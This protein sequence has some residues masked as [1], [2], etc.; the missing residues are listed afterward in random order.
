MET[1]I[2]NTAKFILENYSRPE[3]VCVVL[4][5][6]R[7]GLFLRKKIADSI[8]HPTWA[9]TILGIEEFVYSVSDLEPADNAELLLSLFHSVKKTKGH[10]DDRFEEFCKWAPSLLTDYSEID[11]W[12]ADPKALFTNLADIKNIEGWSL[13]EE[14]LTEFQEKF[15]HFWDQLGPWYFSLREDMLRKKKAW[16]G[17]AH[18]ILAENISGNENLNRWSHIVIVG[19]NA[20]SSSQDKIFTALT[21]NGKAKILW[22]ADRYYLEDPLN[23]AGL[24]LRRQR[25]K[26][27]GG[28]SELNFPH[29]GDNIA[30]KP[31]NITLIAAAR[32]VSQARAAATF[33]SDEGKDFVADETTV[34]LADESLLIPTLNALPQRY[35][36][37]NITMGYPMRSTPVYTLLQ[38]LFSLQENVA[39]FNI[40]ATSGELK[41]YHPDIIRLLRHPYVIASSDHPETLVEII[42]EVGR[43]NLTFA[44]V[45]KL[46]SLVNTAFSHAHW[47]KPWKNA[48]EC[49]SQ[50]RDIITELRSIFQNQ[51]Q[52][53]LDVEY[54]YQFHLTL[55]RIDTLIKDSP[56]FAEISSIKALVLQ[57]FGAGTIPFSGEPLSGLQVMGMLETRC[58]DFK[59][60]IVVSANEG[61][62]PSASSQH[63]FIMYDLRKAF[64]LPVHQERDA[65]TAYN[66]YHLL[67]RAENICLVYN[68]DQEAFG[69]KEKSRYVS[70]LLYELPKQNKQLKIRS[71]IAGAELSSESYS[72]TLSIEG[73]DEIAALA[74]KKAVNGF[75][76]S[77]INTFRECRLRFYFRYIAGLYETEEVDESVDQNMLGTIMH[78]ALEVLYTPYLNKPMLPEHLDAMKSEVQSEVLKAFRSKF[79]DE[80]SDTGRNHLA[81][82]VAT[83]F[84]SQYIEQEKDRIISQRADK[85]ENT[86]IG[87]EQTL[88]FTSQ[89]EGT[90]VTYVGNADRIDQMGNVIRI[91]DYKTGLVE[92]KDVE[93]SG[94]HEFTES[95]ENGKA[96][97]LMMYA[98]LYLKSQNEQAVVQPGLISFRRNDKRFMKL[99]IPEL[100]VL[101]AASIREFE[102][103]LTDITKEILSPETTF[104]QTISVKR[105]GNCEFN[106][107]CRR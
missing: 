107:I 17:L 95:D 36:D 88:K 69:V 46:K 76:P 59:N 22:D 4:P 60:V 32:N 77:L 74:A 72:K 13:G 28:K 58:L 86:V 52:H 53:Q 26:F 82:K 94:T 14:Q 50:L 87:L 89:V 45:S 31:K 70:Q 47:F 38:I 11:M 23:E 93:I 79:P 29:V 83:R 10:E 84:I 73:S 39:R 8:Q 85:T 96:F 61:V 99:E 42:R 104:D 62:L 9:P 90:S 2:G 30:G 105:C 80:E 34:V 92:D 68:T 19:F 1:F 24:F 91:I 64:Q 27:F 100:R 81:R 65:I 15:L 106:A 57:I 97:Q 98:W 33:L 41:F 44:T 67:Q 55:N 56:E 75:S 49:I 25:E 40:V 12:L 21:A 18:R 66:F 43:L 5:N 102:S 103:V 78:K 3:E 48:G 7:A 51:E 37:V 16:I 63:S 6:K 71:L 20:L 54:L 35:S 101:N